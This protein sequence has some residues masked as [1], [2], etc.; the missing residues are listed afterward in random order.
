[1]APSPERSS[2][3]LANAGLVVGG[4]VLVLLAYGLVTRLMGGDVPP[5]PGSAPTGEILQVGVRNATEVEGLAGQARAYLRD[6]G[7]DVVEVGNYSR[8][9]VERSFVIDR[10]GN[11]EQA[12][13]VARSMG[14]DESQVEQDV[15]DDLLLDATVV[16]GADY[17][18]LPAFTED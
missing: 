9:D 18:L 1:M 3:W 16:I 14:I 4:L 6:A 12:R 2:S 10:V 11:L 15:R 17:A 13:R 5:M 8:R 7:F